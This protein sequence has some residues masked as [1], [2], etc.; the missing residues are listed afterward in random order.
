MTAQNPCLSGGAIEIFLEPVLPIPRVLVVGDTPIAAA[1][2][3]LGPELGLDLVPSSEGPP[4]PRPEI[5]RSSSR[6]TGGTSSTRCGRA[7]GR[8]A[9]RRPR[10]EPQAR[11]RRARGAAGRRC[12]RRAARADRHACRA[13][14]RRPHTRRDRA[15]DPRVDR[16][17]APREARRR[18]RKRMRV[19]APRALPTRP[20]RR[21]RSTHLRDDR[22]RRRG[23]ALGGARRRDGLLLLRGLCDGVPGP[24]EHA[25]AAE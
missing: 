12:S 22:C 13:R 5:S 15:L 20:R 21:S 10:G 4:I 16:R 11:R 7:R 6:H 24:D 17:R 9:L 8:R 18:Y 1:V 23:H 19:A 2:L 25:V 3:A 14:H